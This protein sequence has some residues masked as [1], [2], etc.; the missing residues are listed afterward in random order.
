MPTPIERTSGMGAD[1][2]QAQLQELRT[3]VANVKVGLAEVRAEVRVTKHDVANTQ[4]MLV[5][6]DTRLEKT[7]S[8]IGEKLDILTE[9]IAGLNLKH[10]KGVGFY[11]GVG[12]TATICGGFIL[13][14][15]KQ[16]FGV[17]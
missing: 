4:Q 8:A 6:L 7:Q 10:E 16:L 9:K 17:Q 1:D 14:L 3:D 5:G 12:A 13:F 15:I 2:V 11:A